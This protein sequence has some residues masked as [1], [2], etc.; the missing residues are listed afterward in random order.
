MWDLTYPLSDHTGWSCGYLMWTCV[1][2]SKYL[3]FETSVCDTV[4]G[5]AVYWCHSEAQISNE[6]KR[7]V[8]HTTD[9]ILG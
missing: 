8:R 5:L 1:P 7:N 2:L 6:N 4:E 3:D 9:S